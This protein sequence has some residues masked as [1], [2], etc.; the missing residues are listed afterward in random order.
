MEINL[1]LE[2]ARN[3]VK[4][5]ILTEEGMKDFA[6]RVDRADAMDDLRKRFEHALEAS[7]Q[8]FRLEHQDVIKVL[9]QASGLRQINPH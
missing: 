9:E 1:S 3:V 7:N 6:W 8:I 5:R 4:S 2:D